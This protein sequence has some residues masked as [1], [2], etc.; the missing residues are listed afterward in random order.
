MTN[1]NFYNRKKAMW[2]KV[3][4]ILDRYGGESKEL[5]K[6]AI[7]GIFADIFPK[8]TPTQTGLHSRIQ[9]KINEGVFAIDQGIKLIDQS[10][11]IEHE[12]II[13]RWVNRIEN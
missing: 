2:I 6:R 7:V 9:K 5:S 3:A 4:F 1:T 12:E 11:L 10:V 8:Q 13:Q